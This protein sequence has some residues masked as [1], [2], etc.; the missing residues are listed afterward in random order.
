MTMA[1]WHPRAA[2]HKTDILPTKDFTLPQQVGRAFHCGV[3]EARVGERAAQPWQKR[4][5]EKVGHTRI[6]PLNEGKLQ[7][8]LG[9]LGF[10]RLLVC[11]FFAGSVAGKRILD[12]IGMEANIGG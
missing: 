8:W 3:H 9:F 4:H 5:V 12:N 10:C 11:G 2:K 6:C 7:P 1:T